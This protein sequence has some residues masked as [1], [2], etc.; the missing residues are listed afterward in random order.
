MSLFLLLLGYRAFSF[1]TSRHQTLLESIVR[2][3]VWHVMMPM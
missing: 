2:S 1:A 3:L